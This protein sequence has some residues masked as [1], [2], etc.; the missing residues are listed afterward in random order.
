MLKT[1]A[2]ALGLAAAAALCGASAT[3]DDSTFGLKTGTPDIKSAGPLGF[4]PNGILFVGD[5]QGAALFAFDTGDTKEIADKAAIKVEDLAGKVAASLGTDPKNIAINDL[6]VNP[7]SGNIY[8]SVARGKGPDGAPV[9]LRV[10]ANAKIEEVSLENIK[11][12]KTEMPNAPSPTAVQRGQSL[13]AESITDIAF[14]DGRVFVAG[15]SNEEFSSRLLA[16]PFPF[17]ESTDGVGIEIYHGAHG[18]LETK[19]PVR[20]FVATT[21]HHEPYLMAAYTCTPLVKVPVAELKP[22]AH[23]RGTTIA[24]LGN[25]N[26][27]LDMVAYQKDG[28]NF[29]LLANSARGV[30]KIATEGA[31]T[32][33][34]IQAKVADKEGLNYETIN[35]LKGVVQLD[36][37]GKDRA[38]VI[39]KNDAGMMNLETIDLP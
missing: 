12:A 26:R 33:K 36:L 13:R 22:G 10:N 21:I 7:L 11:F 3:A 1:L 25:Q 9:I 20:T 30:M 18:R 31:A 14:A 16:I 38:V 29:L 6:A 8:L 39:V 24:E 27:P 2:T 35:A 17:T 32:A 4:G 37:L 15:L 19:S 34:P 28:K 5:T 23:V